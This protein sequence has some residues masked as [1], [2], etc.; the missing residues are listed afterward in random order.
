MFVYF[1]QAFRMPNFMYLLKLA[2]LAT[3]E[4][5]KKYTAEKQML[6]WKICFAH[7]F[8]L[9]Y[10]CRPAA[11]ATHANKVSL[12]CMDFGQAQ[13]FSIPNGVFD[14]SVWIYAQCRRPARKENIKLLRQAPS[15]STAIII[16][17]TDRRN[18]TWYFISLHH[19]D[20][21]YINTIDWTKCLL[22]QT[23]TK[24]NKWT[25]VWTNEQTNQPKWKVKTK[26]LIFCIVCRSRIC[27]WSVQ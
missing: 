10:N 2:T 14:V 15:N 12:L 16:I 19:R 26:R 7:R 5:K 27:V 9:K 20:K 18:S 23:K 4:S 13:N 6:A 24:T 25:Y 22:M 1:V 17:A 3:I 11:L 21:A 8:H